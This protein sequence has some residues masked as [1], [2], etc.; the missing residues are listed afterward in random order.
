[1]PFRRRASD[2]LFACLLMAACTLACAHRRSAHAL[3][4]LNEDP[5]WPRDEASV[6]ER[7]RY[8]R[9][10][11]DRV[12]KI[13]PELVRQRARAASPDGCGPAG[14]VH[15]LVRFSV[16]RDGIIADAYVAE[17]SG[18]IV[19][20]DTAIDVLLSLSPLE[21]PPAQI[22]AGRTSANL[23]FEFR[24]T[25]NGRRCVRAVSDASG[26]PASGR[27]SRP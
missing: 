5:L 6:A 4:I 20:D 16:N 21:R 8:M 12:A 27:I 2:R 22:L 19:L 15:T 3:E 13:W 25:D 10:I 9:R 17:S 11:H 14:D 24:V 7:E 1:M 23:R 18:L 26:L